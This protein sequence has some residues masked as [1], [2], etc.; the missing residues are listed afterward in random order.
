MEDYVSLENFLESSYNNGNN[1]II[2]ASTPIISLSSDEMVMFNSFHMEKVS[3]IKKHDDR[4][5]GIRSD[6][7][8]IEF[9]ECE[10]TESWGN[11][12][13]CD[14]LVQAN[15]KGLRTISLFT[16]SRIELAKTSGIFIS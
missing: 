16:V 4:F 7:F 9:G 12:E 1:N 13:L 8:C 11:V 10:L 2:I 15:C 14:V 5:C 6:N 3:L